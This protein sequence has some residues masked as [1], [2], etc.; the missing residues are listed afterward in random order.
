MDTPVFVACARPPDRPSHCE[1]CG[2]QT[3]WQVNYV[4][5][6]TYMGHPWDHDAA[7]W[8]CYECL[9]A[10]SYDIKIVCSHD[11]ALIGTKG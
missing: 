11:D 10:A 8:W 9:D 3:R 1:R 2:R 5:H 7:A 6:Y 4:M